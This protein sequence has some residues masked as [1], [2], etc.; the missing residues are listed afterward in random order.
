MHSWG[1]CSTIWSMHSC[2][3]EIVSIVCK[4]IIICF[5][6]KFFMCLWLGSQFCCPVI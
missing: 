4:Y 5:A 2:C 6:Y 3:E 1:F